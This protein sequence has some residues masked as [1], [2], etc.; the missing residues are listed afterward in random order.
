M[1]TSF[2]NTSRRSFRDK[3]EPGSLIFDLK[4]S[5]LLKNYRNWLHVSYKWVSDTHKTMS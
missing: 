4:I 5:Y 1:A 3:H 2:N